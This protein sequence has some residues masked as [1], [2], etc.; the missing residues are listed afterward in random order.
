MEYTKLETLSLHTLDK[1][2]IDSLTFFKKLC[3][4]KTIKTRF[5]GLLPGMLKE[6][7]EDFFNRGFLVKDANEYIGY[8]GIGKY[9]QIEKAV[10]LRAAIDKDKRGRSYGK[11][12]LKEATDYIFENFPQVD[13][14]RLTIAPDNK[15]SL[16]TANA[17]GYNWLESDVY[18]K[19]NPYTRKSNPAHK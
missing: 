13:S 18:Y 19:E 1:D 17:C 6:K 10:Y 15:A 11:T 8:I 7:N 4:D 16:M 2:N 12:L 3:T 9:N 14:I 5:Q